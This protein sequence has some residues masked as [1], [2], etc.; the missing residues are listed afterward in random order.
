MYDFIAD[1]DEYFCE[2]YANY[3]K[4]CVLSG[5][6]MPVMQATKLDEYGREYA[7]TLPASTMRL[8]LQENAKDLLAKLKEDMTDKTF[9]FSFSPIG[10]FTRIGNLFS[11]AAFHKNFK[12]ALNKYKLQSADLLEMLNVDKEIWDGILAGKF[13][14]TQNLLYSIA[15]AGQISFDD[16]KKLMTLCGFSFNYTQERDVVIS[17][18]LSQRVYNRGMVEAALA[19]YKITNLF[20]K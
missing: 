9:S 2:T 4:L 12:I 3:D 7:Y 6:R 8:A 17:Y 13:L 20:L 5:Y 15:I 1:L 11:K 16:T 14:P 19:E 10:V 18:L